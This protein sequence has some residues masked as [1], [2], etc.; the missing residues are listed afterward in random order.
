MS[1]A[2]S[3]PVVANFEDIEP[4][5]CPC[6]WSRRAFADISSSPAS[7]HVVDIQ[8]DAQTHY[9]KKLTEIYFFLECLPDAKMELNGEVIPVHA[10]MSVLI[11]PLTRHR[12]LGRMKVIV[13]AIPRFD[14]HDEWFD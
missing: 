10:G 12:A 7:M 1:I 3:E 6:G 11:P 13:T 14:E 5:R 2:Q 4:V 9:H 8:L